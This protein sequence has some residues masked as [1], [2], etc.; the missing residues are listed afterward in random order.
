[1]DET[2]GTH[3]DRPDDAWVSSTVRATPDGFLKSLNLKLRLT[4]PSNIPV[5]HP[6]FADIKAVLDQGAADGSSDISAANYSEFWNG[7]T[8]SGVKAQTIRA[9]LDVY[10]RSHPMHTPH[11]EFRLIVFRNRLPTYRAN[12]GTNSLD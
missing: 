6:S 4:L 3:Q 12:A 11:Y 9:A 10:A 7:Q 2:G 5:S 1:M 8:L